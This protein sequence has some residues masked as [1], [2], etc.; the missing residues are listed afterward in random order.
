MQV[1][2]WQGVFGFIAMSILLIPFYYI[3]VD[4][5]FGQNP[6][7]V[8]EDALHGFAQLGN[9][10][11]LALAYALTVISIAFFNFAGI[12][13]T[14]EVSATSRYNSSSFFQL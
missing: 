6:R 14:K 13:I 1:V 9:E 12:T 10:P 8:L 11:L 5:T 3:K 4:R 2:G 7:S